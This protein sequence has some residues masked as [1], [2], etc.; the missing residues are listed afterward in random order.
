MGHSSTCDI[1]ALPPTVSDMDPKGMD[2]EC[3][4]S[5]RKNTKGC[6]C[7]TERAAQEMGN[8]DCYAKFG[9][10]MSI[11]KLAMPH[12]ISVDAGSFCVLR[13]SLWTMCGLVSCTTVW[14]TSAR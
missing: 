8:E 13:Y 5:M 1:S 9:T 7:H 4:V 12:K 10:R 3:H 14:M 6:P 2:G 11:Q